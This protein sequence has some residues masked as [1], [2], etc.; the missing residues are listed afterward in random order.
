MSGNAKF[1]FLIAPI[2]LTLLV[3]TSPAI[4]S[5]QTWGIDAQEQ[6]KIAQKRVQQNRK[7]AEAHNN[8]GYYKLILIDYPYEKANGHYLFEAITSFRKALRIKPDFVD[9]H[10][11]LGNSYQKLAEY[12]LA[13]ASYREALRIDPNLTEIRNNLDKLAGEKL[14]REQRL[15]EEE[16]KTYQVLQNL[17]EADRIAR[18]R[19]LLEEERKKLE[20]AEERQRQAQ[21]KKKPPPHKEQ[22]PQSGTGS[23]FFVSKMGHVITNAH[24]VKNC[25]K[26]TWI[27]LILSYS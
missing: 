20:A 3:V 7:N 22:L 1:R 5:G 12:E 6:L 10:I 11:N 21:A 27:H 9:A 14:A 25:K 16:K 24:V 26:V 23:G 2:V 17:K 4:S 15:L 13:I 8:I 19:K 18:E